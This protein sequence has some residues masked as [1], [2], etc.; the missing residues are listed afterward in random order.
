M[1]PEPPTVTTKALVMTTENTDIKDSEM[2]GSNSVFM[3]VN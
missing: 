3:F 1:D 2:A